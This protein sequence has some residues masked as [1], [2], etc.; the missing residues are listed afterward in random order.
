[1]SGSA[2]P[3]AL[4]ERLERVAPRFELYPNY[5]EEFLTWLFRELAAV[6]VRGTPVKNLVRAPNGQAVGWYVYYLAPGGIAETL[7]VAA[8]DGH[9]GMVLD[10]LFWHAARGGAVTLRGRV[11]PALLGPLSQ[12]RVIFRLSN[13]VL[14]HSRQVEVLAA[15]GCGRAFL[16]RLDGEWWMGHHVLWRRNRPSV[17]TRAW[18][19]RRRES[20]SGL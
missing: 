3:A 12:R 16:T 9:L 5:D 19:R 13:W 14:V 20:R 6:D 10:H 8:P 18:R 17:A 7:Q 2:I 15:L 4:L 11:E 1:M